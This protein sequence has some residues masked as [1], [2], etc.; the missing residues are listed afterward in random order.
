MYKMQHSNGNQKRA[1][2]T[3]PT[4]TTT[5]INITGVTKEKI[6]YFVMIQLSTQNYLSI[7]NT[8]APNNKASKYVKSNLAGLKETQ[9]IQP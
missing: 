7:L 1:E 2:V 9:K 4:S 8:Y 5:D 6:E 3:I